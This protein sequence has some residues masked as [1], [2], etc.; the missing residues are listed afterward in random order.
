MS[1]EM[2]DALTGLR[3]KIQEMDTRL[4]A[5]QAELRPITKLFGGNGRPSLEARIYHQEQQVTLISRSAAWS[6]RFAVGAMVGAL[7]TLLW[8]LLSRP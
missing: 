7:G 4:E 2:T 1:N 6:A 5:I 8:S 3:D